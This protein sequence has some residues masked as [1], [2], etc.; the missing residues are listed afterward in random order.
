M[1]DDHDNLFALQQILDTSLKS[2][3]KMIKTL[4]GI[5]PSYRWR[6]DSNDTFRDFYP[7]QD[8]DLGKV[9]V[10]QLELDSTMRNNSVLDRDKNQYIEVLYYYEKGLYYTFKQDGKNLVPDDQVYLLFDEVFLESS[11]KHGLMKQ[12]VKMYNENVDLTEKLSEESF[13]LKDSDVRPTVL[14]EIRSKVSELRQDPRY[15]Y[16]QGRG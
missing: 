1:T 2:R 4:F 8:T 5:S 6:M 16:N 9:V 15:I 7:D 10:L 11:V 12:L 13:S 3:V 14:E